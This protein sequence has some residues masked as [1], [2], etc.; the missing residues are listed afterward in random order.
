MGVQSRDG[1]R[2]M[3]LVNKRDRDIEILVAGA[4]GARQDYV[5]LT[6]KFDPP[7]SAKVEGEKITLRGLAVVV[8]TLP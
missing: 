8:V 3:L 1:K 5:D 2:R 4:A 6:T 7:S